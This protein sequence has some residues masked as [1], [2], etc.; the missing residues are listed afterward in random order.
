MAKLYFKKYGTGLVPATPPGESWLAGM[1]QGD[2]IE[3]QVSRPRNY[4]FLQKA[5]TLVNFLFE[6]W[7]LPDTNITEG[8]PIV[9]D[10]EAFREMLTIDAGKYVLTFDLN[11]NFRPRAKSWSYAEMEEHEFSELYSGIID[12]G[13]QKILPNSYTGEELQKEV[14]RAMSWA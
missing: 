4:R 8:L 13:L 9:K 6:R 3:V 1:G 12:V 2:I 14:D 5:F 7:N 10:Y 11:G